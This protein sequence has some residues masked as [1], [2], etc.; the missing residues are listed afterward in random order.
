MVGGRVRESVEGPLNERGA[1][2]PIFAF[3]LLVL[4]IF[5]ALATDLGA[6]WAERRTAQ[7]TVD[8]A[9]MAAATEYLRPLPPDEAKTVEIV[10]DYVNRNSPDPEPTWMDL[11]PDWLECSDPARPSPFV[12]LAWDTD[13]DSVDEVFECI[14]FDT[15]G[16][17]RV[18]LPDTAVATFFAKI[19]AIDSISVS[20]SAVAEIRYIPNRI[21]LPLSLPADFVEGGDQC[22]ATAPN[23]LLPGDVVPCPGPAQGNFGLLDSPWFGT[24]D[25]NFT[26]TQGCPNDPNFNT[27]APHNLAI[28]LDH[29]ITAWPDPAT[30]PPD[31]TW[32]GN[33]HEGADSCVNAVADNAPYVLNTQPGNTQSA[34]GKALLQD[35]FLGDDPSPTAASLPGRLRQATPTLPPS[36]SV[37]SRI[38]FT[39]N[40]GSYDV[41]NVGLWEYLDQSAINNN[42]PCSDTMN[43]FA[44][45]QGRQLTDQ[46]MLCLA[47]G[48]AR[49]IGE[50]LDSPRFGVVPVL[51]YQQGAQYGSKWWAVKEMRPVYL[52][53]SW[54]H[55]SSGASPE[56]RF[57]PNDFT[58]THGAGN[59]Y[60][61]LHNPGEG[62]APP[63]TSN[64]GTPKANKFQIMGTSS[65]VL[66]W[67]WFHPDDLNQLHAGTPYEVFLYR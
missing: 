35:G 24:G 37:N 67:D 57:Q 54:Y 1:V 55:C 26:D 33:N 9:V 21:V 60:S 38:T 44:G 13:G 5:A 59:P 22:L 2:A 17:L 15:A 36:P 12:P 62:E 63:Q 45:L 43:G 3:I 19:I 49:F 58:S 32:L 39:T 4:L 65:V 28:G 6:A 56:C 16:L 11:I 30:L 25:P 23:G 27:R 47:S 48:D 14:S 40:T 10:L 53:T 29:I 20:A 50:L 66:S 34:G 8:A 51:N 31:G 7:G 61:I 46:M 18:R 42:S 41:D 52:Q 64:G